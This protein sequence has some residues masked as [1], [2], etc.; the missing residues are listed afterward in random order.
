MEREQRAWVAV[1]SAEHEAIGRAQGFMQF[2][3]GK[4]AP[5]RRIAAGE[6][7]VYYAPA[8]GSAVARPVALSWRWAMSARMRRV[9]WKWRRALPR[10]GAM[11]IG[12]RPSPPPSP[13]C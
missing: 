2:C 7:V 13:P 9:R 12:M 6:A 4:A 10:G 11:W 5:L 1:A 8:P 3:H